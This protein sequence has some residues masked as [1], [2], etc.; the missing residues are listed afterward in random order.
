M[1]SKIKILLIILLFSCVFTYTICAFSISVEKNGTIQTT[2]LST[3]LLDDNDFL[4]KIQTLDSTITSIDKENDLTRSSTINDE[5]LNDSH[6]F[7]TSTSNVPT[8]LWIDN[9][10]I[11]YFTI[12]TSIDLNTN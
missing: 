3:I 5:V 2:E 1:K 8:Y 4:T 10:T 12:A 6:V 7:S 9:G 11:Y